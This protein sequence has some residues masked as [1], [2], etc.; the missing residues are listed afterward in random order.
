MADTATRLRQELRRAGI[1]DTVL[2]ALLT[3]SGEALYVLSTRGSE[4]IQR[5]RWLR[6]LVPQT[7]H[8]PV[9]VGQDDDLDALREQVQSSDFGTTV[10]I[11]DSA[12]AIDVAQW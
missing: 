8:W 2:E 3:P 5:W 1:D 12:S 9:L 11:L 10:D 7:A 4:A 6:E